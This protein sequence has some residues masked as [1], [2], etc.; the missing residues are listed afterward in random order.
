MRRDTKGR[1]GGKRSS[2]RPIAELHLVAE[3]VYLSRVRSKYHVRTMTR[4]VSMSPART[5]VSLPSSI[6][7]FHRFSISG[8]DNKG[9]R[10]YALKQK[11]ED[12]YLPSFRS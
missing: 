8:T 4:Q 10:S 11:T 3:G 7:C 5:A 1:M 9:I 12:N 6:S 2:S